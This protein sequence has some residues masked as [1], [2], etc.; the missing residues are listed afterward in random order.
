[1]KHKYM[2][3]ILPALCALGMLI[4]GAAGSRDGLDHMTAE[5]GAQAM[6]AAPI[7]SS[8]N[9]RERIMAAEDYANIAISQVTDYVNIR[10]EP[11]T[12]STIVGKIYNNCAATILATVEGEDGTWYQIQSGTVSGYIKAQYF[13]TGAEAD[14]IAKEIGIEYATINT[15]A[16]RLRAEPNLT[17]ETLT[18]LVQG[19]EYVVLEEVDNF[20]KLSVD[21]DM[22]GY[23]SMDYIETRV[24]FQQA[25]SLEEEAAQQAEEA[26]RIQEAQEAIQKLEEVKLVE[27]REA[28]SSQSDSETAQTTTAAAET[29][30]TIPANPLGDGDDPRVS[31]PPGSPATTVASV[32]TTAAET[33]ASTTSGSVSYGPGGTASTAVVSATRT[34]IVAYA[35]QFLGNPYVYGGTSLTDGA[36]CSGFVMRIFEHFG[37]DTG[38]SSRDQATNA[39]Q[40][41]IDEVEPGDLLFYANGDYINHVA[42]YIGGGQVIHAAS[43]QTGI[44]ISPSNYRTPYMAATFLD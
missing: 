42:I 15:A 27:A 7:R 4:A 30:G 12:S 5:A 33:A 2:I 36:D 39:R 13:V 21:E 9:L 37:I 28:Q 44:T 16:L 38:R 26:R 23:V 20:A 14:A 35:K 31:A 25:V 24:E 29:V 17:S 6:A 19:A 22:V 11:N 34:A 32:D 18:M 3:C 1:M 10:E 41:E 40:I 43:S 8:R